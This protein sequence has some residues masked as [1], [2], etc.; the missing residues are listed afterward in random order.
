MQLI[1]LSMFAAMAVL[2][3]TTAA[4]IT[5]DRRSP[6]CGPI[7]GQSSTY[8][9]YRGKTGPFPA[10]DLAPLPAN[11]DTTIG[12][13]DLTF[14]NL[15]SAE[16]L[17]FSFYQAGVEAFNSS[18]FTDLGYPNTTYDRITE[19]RDNEA[20]HLRIFQN[21]ISNASLV[22]GS[23]K[24]DYDFGTDASQYLALQQLFE[25]TSMAF[26]SGMAL[27]VQLEA[28]KVAIVA[29]ATIETRH[30]VWSLQ[31]VFGVSP[32]AGPADTAYPYANQILN[33]T[34]QFI[35]PGSCPSENPP[36]PEPSQNLIEMET[37]FNSSSVIP[38]GNV[39]FEFNPQISF[40][41]GKD[42]FV[43]FNHGVEN[44]TVPF[45]IQSQSAIIPNFDPKG[46]ALAVLAD[47]PGA[48]TEDS[49]LA[50]PD[51][52]VF[53]PGTLGQEV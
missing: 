32:F 38:G 44:V 24:Y 53:Q 18:S 30:A 43:V 14:Q 17:V 22:P 31:D 26:L 21:S 45:E 15:M 25:I 50:G 10:D 2:P 28:N 48:P 39:T 13:D 33:V 3:F 20:G 12:T 36:Y 51:I 42:Y 47:T 19:I 9:T 1:A 46:V 41:S 23:C 29:I 11:S 52:L 8:N 49:V 27:E 5:C 40:D 35:V 4:P 37:V 6:S 34:R 7:P 16:W